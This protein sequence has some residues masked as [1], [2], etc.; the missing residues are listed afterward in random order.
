MQRTPDDLRHFIDSH[1]IAATLVVPPAETPT[2]PAAAAAMGCTEDE[3]IKSVLFLIED[4]VPPRPV[5]VIACGTARIDYRALAARF[6]VGRKRVR[7]APAE[8]VLATLGYP[9]GGV[10]PFGHAT[11]VPVLMDEAV[12]RQEVVYGG[13]G[14]DQ[15]LVRLTVAE[16]RRVTG[17]ELLAVAQPGADRA[18]P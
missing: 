15:S 10:P 14:D 7:L 1:S 16:L 11:A 8:V 3:I 12:A 18:T 17:A 13:G 2:V 5:L 4:E 6:G 9:A